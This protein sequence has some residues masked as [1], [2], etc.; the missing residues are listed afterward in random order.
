M[1][2]PSLKINYAF[3]TLYDAVAVLLPFVTMPYVTRVLGPDNC[4][5]YSFTH[6]NVTYFVLLATL[7]TTGYGIRT[8]SRNRN[9]KFEY[10]KLF[11]EIELLTVVSSVISIIGFFVFYSLVSE[12][13]N[14]Y[15]ILSLL[16]IS[17]ML[18]ISWL[19]TGLEH[20]GVMSS[21]NV[22]IKIIGATSIFLFVK[23]PDDLII[24]FHIN[25]LVIFASNLSMWIIAPR[26]LI[27]IPFKELKVFRHIKETLIF[28]IPTIAISI[29]TVLDKT[30]I[31]L[32]THE[33]SQNG[34]YDNATQLIGGVKVLVYT[35][36]GYVMGAR[37]SF[38]FAENKIEEVKEKIDL[39]MNYIMFLAIGSGLGI[40]SVAD[41]F[42]PLFLGEKFVGAVP[43]LKLMTP[44]IA[45]IG[46][47]NC[48]GSLYYSPVGKRK[49]SAGFIVIGSITNLVLNL[50]LIPRFGAAGATVG[51]IIAESTISILY[52]SFCDNFF[53][54]KKLFLI[55]YK[56]IIA[57]IIM[58]GVIYIVGSIPI[59][60]GIVTAIQILLG[61]LSYIFFLIIFKDNIVISFLCIVSNRIK[62]GNRE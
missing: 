17:A 24:Y 11:W 3:R 29:Y 51:S 34:Y 7:G 55:V 47:S 61:G 22:V 31:G 59:S 19:F 32:I 46:I 35:S 56:K 42:V 40:L 26:Y 18:D 14:Y 27:R 13:K 38:L 12:Y 9:N 10:S 60:K 8:I 6:A 16:I 44:L 1:N 52:L 49:T 50:I 25:V 15:L 48:L 23:S 21:V 30:L 53:T 39:S 37:T 28:F 57:G 54:F 2:K 43:I 58:V 33:T 5:I 4:G 41:N 45:I 20:I 36:I 62:S